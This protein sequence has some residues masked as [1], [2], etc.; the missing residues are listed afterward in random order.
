ME[1]KKDN[2]VGRG[3]GVNHVK[4]SREL[5]R[6][7]SCVDLFFNFIDRYQ[8]AETVLKFVNVYEKI[9]RHNFHVTR[10]CRILTHEIPFLET[11]TLLCCFVQMLTNLL[12]TL[13]VCLWELCT[14]DSSE[15]LFSWFVLLL[16]CTRR[17]A[18][19]QV[20]YR[21]NT[22]REKMITNSMTMIDPKAVITYRTSL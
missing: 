21:S 13:T 3:K 12:C 11:E 17:I 10:S 19:L 2:N 8:I 22:P 16:S 7:K 14:V 18:H 5:I 20:K 6:W 1:K 15:D 9:N 4:I